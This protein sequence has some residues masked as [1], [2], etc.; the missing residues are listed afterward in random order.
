[1]SKRKVAIIGIDSITPVMI[2]RFMAEG[3][4]PNL[5]RMYERG[6][7]S[8][9]TSTMPPTTP[10]AWTTVATG[11]WPSTHGIEGFA[12]HRPGDPLDHKLHSLTSDRVRAEQLWQLAER[13][14]MDSVL[15][16]WPVS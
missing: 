2:E 5:R 14:G 3:R 7:S 9:I 8:E 16:K 6:W 13:H 11:A 10:A 15:L 4:M 12:V 1:M